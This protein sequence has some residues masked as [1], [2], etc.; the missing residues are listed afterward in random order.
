MRA[1][2]VKQPWASMIASGIKSIETRTKPTRYRGDILIVSSLKADT[3]ARHL[4]GRYRVEYP[5]GMALCVANLIACDPMKPEDYERAKC[6]YYLDLYSWKL[7]DI[8]PINPFPVKGMLGLY[9]VDVEGKIEFM[10]RGT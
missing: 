8:R 9:D 5:L 10:K 2:S 3:F 1:L 4:Q 7:D 6:D